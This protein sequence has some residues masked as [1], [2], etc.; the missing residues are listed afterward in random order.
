MPFYP[1]ST[2]TEF[3]DWDP[4]TVRPQLTEANI[5]GIEAAIWCETIESFADAC[6]LLLP[7]LPGVLEKGWSAAG[8]GARTWEDYA[9]R[10]SAQASIWDACG[11][12][13]FRSEVVW[14]GDA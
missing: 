7:R 11:W 3:Y 4:A 6:F 9:P 14:R 12:P 1:K 13:W 2:V 5:A 10:L 8:G